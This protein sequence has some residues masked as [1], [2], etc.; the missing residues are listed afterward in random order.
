MFRGGS[1]PVISRIRLI[2]LLL[3]IPGKPK[4]TFRH[5]LYK[6]QPKTIKLPVV[7]STRQQTA[8]GRALAP[9]RYRFGQNRAWPVRFIRRTG[10][11][12]ASRTPLTAPAQS[13]AVRTALI[14]TLW[15]PIYFVNE[16]KP[17]KLYAKS[18]A[19]KN[20][21]SFIALHER[22]TT[23]G[24]TPRLHNLHNLPG[25]SPLSSSSFSFFGSF[26]TSP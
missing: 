22:R 12:T 9:R 18:T 26:C 11:I 3:G 1:I 21:E 14:R 17:I 7:H 6:R 5:T 4:N 2:F 10:R 24:R 13:R 8:N 23:A 19:P 20:P 25:S 16:G 15:L